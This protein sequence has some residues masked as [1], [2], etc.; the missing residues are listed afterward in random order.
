[1][2]GMVPY[3]DRQPP[4]NRYRH[5]LIAPPRAGA[6]CASAMEWLDAPQRDV[7]GV[8]QDRRCRRCG[9]TVQVILRELRDAAWIARRCVG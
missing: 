3:T 7:R 4:T 9:F 5:Q 2:S 1:M 6:C 8:C